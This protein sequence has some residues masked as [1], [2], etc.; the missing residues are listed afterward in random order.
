LDVD[1]VVALLL[2]RFSFFFVLVA[3]LKLFFYRQ[4]TKS[5]CVIVRHVVKNNNNNNREIEPALTWNQQPVQVALPRRPHLPPRPAYASSGVILEAWGSLSLA[6]STKERK[7]DNNADGDT[8]I[9]KEQLVLRDTI[10][11]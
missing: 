8:I 11:Y 1:A 7:D 2:G 9:T 3:L 10:N 6:Q 5:Y 4:G